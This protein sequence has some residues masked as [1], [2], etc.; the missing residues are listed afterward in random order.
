M[1][2]LL[3]RLFGKRYKHDYS[4]LLLVA[5]MAGGPI[6]YTLVYLIITFFTLTKKPD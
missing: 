4:T 6:G 1:T 2:P 3:K 5:T